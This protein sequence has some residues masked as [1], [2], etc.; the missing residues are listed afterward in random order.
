MQVTTSCL[1]A[2]YSYDK[3]WFMIASARIKMSKRY[4]NADV[5]CNHILK[6]W[7]N[8][9]LNVVY[10]RLDTNRNK[11]IV[12]FSLQKLNHQLKITQITTFVR[13]RKQNNL[14]NLYIWFA[15]SARAVFIFHSLWNK[16]ATGNGNCCCFASGCLDIFDWFH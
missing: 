16:H 15:R 2:L 1:E 8:Q 5:H 4:I 6:F 14:E 12:L 9:H 10:K 11:W 13:E 7:P 3:I